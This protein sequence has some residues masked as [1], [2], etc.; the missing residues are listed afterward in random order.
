MTDAAQP[1]TILTTVGGRPA[2]LFIST[3]GER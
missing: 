2:V 3:V 1:G